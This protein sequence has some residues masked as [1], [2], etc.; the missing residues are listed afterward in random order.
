MD[1]LSLILDDMRLQGGVFVHV[2]LTAPWA[3][4]LHTP[5]LASFHIMTSGSAWLL[6]DGAEPLYVQQGDLVILPAGAPHTLVDR[7]GCTAPPHDLL[8]ELTN[9][10]DAP[11]RV[12]GGGTRATVVSGHARFDVMMASPLVAALPPV[13]HIRAQGDQPPLW[14]AIGLQ[15]LA[16][17]VSDARPAQQTVINRLGDIMFIECLRDY[18]ESLPEGSDNWL[19]ALRDKAL[20]ITLGHMHRDPAHNWTVQELAQ[21]ACLSR[22]AFAERFTQTVGQPPLAYL[23]QHRMRL[24]ARQLST[25]SQPVNRIANLV[26]YASEAAFSQAFKRE[27]GCSPSAYREQ[28]ALALA[29]PESTPA[30]EP[31][32]PPDAQNVYPA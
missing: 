9:R 6:R 20:S 13:M 22:S 26:G 29:T 17:E 3:L 25:S 2:E 12:G 5:G 23:T 1:T 10:P 15:F 21:L 8:P 19:V 27:Y 11:L 28:P 14:L 30:D 31:G 24:A 32:P 7:Q 18:V 4:G 16:Q